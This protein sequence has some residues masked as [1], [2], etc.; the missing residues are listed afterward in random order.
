MRDFTALTENCALGICRRTSYWQNVLFCGPTPLAQPLHA[1]CCTYFLTLYGNHFFSVCGLDD[2][3]FFQSLPQQLF[4]DDYLL[5]LY[6]LALYREPKRASGRR[7]LGWSGIR[8]FD[9][10]LPQFAMEHHRML[11]V[12]FDRLEVGS[13]NSPPRCERAPHGAP[14]SELSLSFSSSF[15]SSLWMT[16]CSPVSDVNSTF[17]GGRSR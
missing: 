11:V 15:S 2:P 5:L 12:A 6:L 16:I 3:P 8:P 17:V 7:L 13:N 10:F 14:S 1:P 9:P 4:V